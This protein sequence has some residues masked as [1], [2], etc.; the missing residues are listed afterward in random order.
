MNVHDHPVFEGKKKY[1]PTTMESDESGNVFY[2]YKPDDELV[3][4]VN[5][6][7]ALERP[8]LLEGDPGC[9]KTCLAN[10]I[11]YEFTQHY[12][13]DE[14]RWWPFYTWPIKSSSRYRDGLYTFDAVLRLRDAQMMGT[15]PA[16]LTTYLPTESVKIK[17][18]LEQ[19]SSYLKYGPLGEAMRPKTEKD[20]QWKNDYRPIV[21]IDEIDK[22]DSDFPND[23]LREIETYTFEMPVLDD[24]HTVQQVPA[25]TKPIIIITS[26]RERPLPE[27]FLRR[28]IYYYVSFPKDQLT[29]IIQLRFGDRLKS[30]DNSAQLLTKARER[31]TSIQTLITA[32]PGHRSPG[33]SEFLD[34]MR[35]LLSLKTEAEALAILENLEQHKAILGTLLKS[36]VLHER[37]LK[38]HQG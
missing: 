21:L 1:Q 33:L 14:D 11:A 9:G 19:A 28:C 2:P 10:A 18:R 38:E 26:N 31:F 17:G 22:A 3:E 8:L 12:L 37:Y 32:Q 27:P 7:I 24:P 5:L 20:D 6:V 25:E 29:E 13:K 15:D 34:F 23:L 36:S 4:A 35:V 30:L 16:T